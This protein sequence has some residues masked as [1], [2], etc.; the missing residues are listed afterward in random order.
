MLNKV[1]TLIMLKKAR[2]FS[3]LFGSKS[4]FIPALLAKRQ[5][6]SSHSTLKEGNPPRHYRGVIFLE[7]GMDLQM[8][9]Q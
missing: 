6:S 1:N 9:G 8:F 3:T 5:S 7:N 4:Y 2:T